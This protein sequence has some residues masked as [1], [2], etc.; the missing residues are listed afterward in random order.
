[1]TSQDGIWQ[2]AA[3]TQLN[4]SIVS[5]HS[6]GGG[7]F[8]SSFRAD[9]EDGRAIFIKTHQNPPAGFFTAEAAGLSWLRSTGAIL[10]PEVV[11]V[12]DEPPFLALEWIEGGF[13]AATTDD[14]FGRSLARHHMV[15]FET[16]GRPD[17]KTTG[18]QAMDNRPSE[19]WSEFY[20]QRRI[21]PLTTKA[22][23]NG[24]IAPTT[25][26]KLEKLV[27]IIDDVIGPAE[28]PA[29]LHGDLWAGNRMIDRQGQSWVIDPASF[30]GNREF[31]IALMQLFGG[32]SQDAFDAYD[33]VY[34]LADGW[35]ERIPLHQLATLLVHA[36]KFGGGYGSA[37]DRAVDRYV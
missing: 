17:G 16:F 12:G 1:M 11:A 32:F 28:V 14:H 30:G 19:T 6:I 24:A 34:P 25:V 9:L 33:E 23:N 3:E 4:S 35:V 37:V 36:I 29:C 18:S 13:A 26:T 7:D 21:V 10:V 5:L 2:D 8:A 20:T 15:G 31:D 27:D 22:T